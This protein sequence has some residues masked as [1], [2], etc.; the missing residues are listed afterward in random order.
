[1]E[2]WI[3]DGEVGAEEENGKPSQ[4]E[5]QQKKC[6]KQIPAA[7]LV[8]VAPHT[9]ARDGMFTTGVNLLGSWQHFWRLCLAH[10]GTIFH[11]FLGTTP[12]AEG[13]PTSPSQSQCAM[14]A[15]PMVS[16]STEV[17]GSLFTAES[18]EN[19]PPPKESIQRVKVCFWSRG[20]WLLVSSVII[21]CKPVCGEDASTHFCSVKRDGDED[22]GAPSIWGSAGESTFSCDLLCSSHCFFEFQSCLG[23][24]TP[25]WH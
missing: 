20:T 23:N 18:P 21:T 24:K 7:A 5:M 8:N 2:L 9:S 15:A 10:S 13:N 22:W 4:E 1:M 3:K 19:I 14:T 11:L 12:A 6:N 17:G 16:H 25:W